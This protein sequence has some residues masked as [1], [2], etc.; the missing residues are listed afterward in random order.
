MP[1]GLLPE[2]PEDKDRGEDDG[3]HER[4]PSALR[5]LREHG[6]EKSSVQGCENEVDRKDNIYGQA[7]DQDGHEGGHVSR[8]EGHEDDADAVGVPKGSCLLFT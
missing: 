3:Q 5:H 7:P 2:A 4:E 1:L 6:A 8:D